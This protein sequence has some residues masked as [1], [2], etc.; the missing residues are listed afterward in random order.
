MSIGSLFFFK[1]YRGARFFCVLATI[2][3]PRVCS[4]HWLQLR[5]LAA[6]GKRELEIRY[7]QEVA[8]YLSTVRCLLA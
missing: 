6:S 3:Y 4:K 5:L 8:K 2:F 7:A 1:P